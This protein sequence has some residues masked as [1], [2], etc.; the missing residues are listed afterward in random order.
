MANTYTIAVELCGHVGVKGI[1]KDTGT[2]AT[3]IDAATGYS[4]GLVERDGHRQAAFEG[5]LV[6]FRKKK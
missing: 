2:A 4:L 5:C 3:A 1:A 6:G